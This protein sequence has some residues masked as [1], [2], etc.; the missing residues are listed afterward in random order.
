M[1]CNS[2]PL[3]VP[4]AAVFLIPRDPETA[5]AVRKLLSAEWEELLKLYGSEG[6]LGPT[7]TSNITDLVTAASV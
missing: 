6:I 2:I 7:G 4:A 1:A 3:F 5:L